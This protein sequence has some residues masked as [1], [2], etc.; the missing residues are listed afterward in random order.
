MNFLVNGI[1]IIRREKVDQRLNFNGI[2]L[3]KN[4]ADLK[5][6]FLGGIHAYVKHI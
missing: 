2:R 5:F 6:E 4:Q 3:R 1:S